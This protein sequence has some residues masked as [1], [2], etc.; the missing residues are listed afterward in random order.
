MPIALTT[1]AEA[2]RAAAGEQFHNLGQ[3]PSYRSMLDFE[4][5]TGP[6]DVAIV[7]DETALDQALDRLEAS[8]VTEFA[9]ALFAPDSEAVT[10]TRAYLAD[11]ASRA[12]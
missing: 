2:A 4:G 11:R 3:L 1:D 6:A 8:G 9:G 10:R 5:A 12:G 7:G